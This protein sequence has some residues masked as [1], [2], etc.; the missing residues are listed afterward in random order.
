M[1]FA[2]FLDYRQSVLELLVALEPPNLE[3]GDEACSCDGEAA[4]RRPEGAPIETALKD[5]V[6]IEAAQDR[7]S[8]HSDG[9]SHDETTPL[10]AQEPQR[11]RHGA[12]AGGV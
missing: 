6:E 1:L 7:K 5:H 12:G 9:D 8:N 4:H 11:A 3:Q 2:E 10:H